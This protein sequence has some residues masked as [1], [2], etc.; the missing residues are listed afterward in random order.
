MF[1]F[2]HALDSLEAFTYHQGKY[3]PGI[4]PNAY[5]SVFLNQTYVPL[6]Y[7]LV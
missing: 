7:W 3:L 2:K 5:L 6:E 4:Y 1:Y